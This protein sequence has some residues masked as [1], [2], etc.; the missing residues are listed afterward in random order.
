MPRQVIGLIGGGFKPFTAGHYLLVTKASEECDKVILFVSTKDRARPG[1]LE[2]TWGMMQKVWDRFLLKA[3]PA[4]LKVVYSPAP[5]KGVLDTLIKANG[6]A[7]DINTYVIYSDPEDAE[8]NYSE[9]RQ[10]QYM[11]RLLENDQIIVAPIPRDPSLGGM[12]ISGTKMRGYLQ[13]GLV[14]S[15]VKGLPGPVQLYGPKIFQM[16]GGKIKKAAE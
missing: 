2:I 5:V 10:Q 3:M 16:L 9:A 4:N 15:F 14:K 13:R 6:N 12:N 7:R 1:E 11:P 8:K